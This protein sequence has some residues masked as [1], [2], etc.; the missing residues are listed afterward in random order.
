MKIT[1]FAVLLLGCST[2]LAQTQTGLCMLSDAHRTNQPDKA[3]LVLAAADCGEDSER[4][5][6]VNN[7]SMEWSR[8]TGIS[9]EMLAKEKPHAEGA[10]ERRRGRSGLQRQRP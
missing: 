1:A 3:Q 6:D 5:T 8:W 4:C 10:D 2:G 7:S 9:A